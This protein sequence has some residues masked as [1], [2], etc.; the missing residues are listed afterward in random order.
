MRQLRTRCW[1]R[2]WVCRPT[3]SCTS[4]TKLR[5][6]TACTACCPLDCC[7]C[8]K[9]CVEVHPGLLPSISVPHIVVMCSLQ[10]PLTE[11]FDKVLSPGQLQ[12]LISGPHT[13]VR[14]DTMSGAAA[15]G[16]PATPE[17]AAARVAAGGVGAAAG[18]LDTARATTALP[19]SKV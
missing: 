8:N 16:Q 2:S 10:P 5:C 11:I 15:G 1:L 6:V 14:V 7:S 13:M 17:A 4:R 3:W 19:A 12:A 18:G 9:V